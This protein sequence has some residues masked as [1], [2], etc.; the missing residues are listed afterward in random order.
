M[1]EQILVGVT[2][3]VLAGVLGGVLALLYRIIEFRRVDRKDILDN[4]LQGE[5]CKTR[6]ILNRKYFVKPTFVMPHLYN[7]FKA[8]EDKF[9]KLKDI[10]NFIW[11]NGYNNKTVLLIQGEAGLG[12]TRLI[13]YLVYKLIRN[14]ACKEVLYRKINKTGK[15]YFNKLSLVK[16][17]DDLVNDIK[18]KDEEA[19]GKLK[20]LFLD[21]FDEFPLLH[22]YNADSLLTELFAK[23]EE[24]FK[25][26]FTKVIITSR[27][28]HFSRENEIKNAFIRTNKGYK[29][30]EYIKLNTLNKRQIIKTWKSSVSLNSDKI[31]H[32][33]R[34]TTLRKL[35]EYMR[36][37]KKN[38]KAH[39][40]DIFSN[41]FFVSCANDIIA[42]LNETQMEKL[43]HQLAIDKIVEKGIEREKQ[44]FDGKIDVSNFEDT[45]LS[46]LTKMA[47][48]I[49]RKIA[50][51][52]VVDAE[53]NDFD[54]VQTSEI[55]ELSKYIS[56]R[57]LI[58]R[59][60]G[61]LKFMH[62][63]LLEYF[64][65]RG[66]QDK[67][68]PYSVSRKILCD[69]TS[70]DSKNIKCF[71]AHFLCQTNPQFLKYAINEILESV[72]TK[73][74]YDYYNN[75]EIK[76]YNH[77]LGNVNNPNTLLF[78]NS[79][80][81]FIKDASSISLDMLFK[82]FP[83]LDRARFMK[84]PS[85]EFS[86]DKEG[87]D[88][89]YIRTN[90]WEQFINFSSM[91]LQSQYENFQSIKIKFDFDIEDLITDKYLI[92]KR[93]VMLCKSINE[94][95]PINKISFENDGQ[96]LT[97]CVI[98]RIGCIEI[99]CAID[100]IH[101]THDSESP[102]FKKF[103]DSIERLE[104]IY[105]I[106]SKYPHIASGEV[107]IEIYLLSTLERLYRKDSFIP[108]FSTV[109]LGKEYEAL[110]KIVEMGKIVE[111]GE[112]YK[113]ELIA[114]NIKLEE[115][116]NRRTSL[117]KVIELNGKIIDIDKNNMD[118][119]RNRA[120]T[121][122]CMEKIGNA[123]SDGIKALENSN[124][125]FWRLNNYN[126]LGDY[127]CID[128]QYL[129]AIKC[130]DKVISLRSHPEYSED[131][132]YYDSD[133]FDYDNF[134]LLR[135]RRDNKN[136]RV[137]MNRGTCYYLIGEKE[138]AIQDKQKAIE[139]KPEYEHRFIY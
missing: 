110:G 106:Y 102:T 81:L 24:N 115:F 89:L 3:I 34:K 135:S 71:Y 101:R 43:T 55:T 77:I 25:T 5:D 78:V 45:L 67:N 105:D 8:K 30:M 93:I 21:G 35:K 17:I 92:T 58:V 20:Y 41:S 33:D 54:S 122:A 96:I 111:F 62:R 31:S 87:I 32:N 7:D 132:R 13:L 91:L 127:Y 48:V 44:F 18:K 26:K 82:I 113:K 137:Y 50:K 23:I 130:Y 14:E 22:I 134:K 108:S 100:K 60:G 57:A 118:A 68:M 6:K 117:E 138:K 129:E 10:E 39:D 136:A 116:A 107:E 28:E 112:E 1:F 88:T 11:K 27:I 119:Y 12:K 38:G 2:I 124:C 51:Y 83:F 56:T 90:S 42:D 98:D 139:L 72:E 80:E 84:Y 109:E 131:I 36:I 15:V 53:N 114:Y 47:I 29:G 9:L 123:I 4:L 125:V 75:L 40:S 86:L 121:Y 37:A 63:L 120:Q 97:K 66:I 76:Q 19:K 104:L 74:R 70:L 69:N 85:M 59:E 61:T 64:I 95:L 16:S 94:L 49:A 52:N 65:A 133:E 99:R 128:G 103:L 79:K 73:E 126:S 46:I